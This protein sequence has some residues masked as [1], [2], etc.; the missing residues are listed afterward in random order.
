MTIQ[1]N[2]ITKEQPEDLLVDLIDWQLAFE[3]HLAPILL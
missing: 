2:P 1:E 3:P